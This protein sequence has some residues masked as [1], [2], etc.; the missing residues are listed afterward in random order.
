MIKNINGTFT[1]SKWDYSDPNFKYHKG[2]VLLN[3]RM[4]ILKFFPFKHILIK[5]CFYTVIK[6]C[7]NAEQILL[8][9]NW[10]YFSF[11]CGKI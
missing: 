5:S 10:Q 7:N 1:T 4:H 11:S 6:R 8:K 3:T 9:Y 2:L